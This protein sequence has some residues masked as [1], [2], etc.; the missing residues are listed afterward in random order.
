[1]RLKIFV[2]PCCNRGRRFATIAALNIH[3]GKNHTNFGY[4]IFLKNNLP[5]IK[6]KNARAQA[7]YI[8]EVVPAH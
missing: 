4:K 6:R 8:K 5:Y 3:I 2:C 7:A 1:M